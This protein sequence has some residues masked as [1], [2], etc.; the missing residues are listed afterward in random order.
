[1]QATLRAVQIERMNGFGKQRNGALGREDRSPEYLEDR[2]GAFIVGGP[3]KWS[4]RGRILV[5]SGVILSAF[6]CI[7]LHL[8]ASC[9]H[10]I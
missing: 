7:R 4:V 1:M 3:K 5:C 10:M 8:W 6:V 9:V 2:L